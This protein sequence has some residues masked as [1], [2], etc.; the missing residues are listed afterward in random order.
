MS[1]IPFNVPRLVKEGAWLD[2]RGKYNNG[3]AGFGDR[4]LS[5][6]RFAA[7][8]HSV[9]NP[10]GNAER[11]CNTLF[12]IHAGNGWN[13]IGYNFV[14]TSE[15]VNGFAK[16]A[17][18]G[19]LGSVRAHTPNTKGAKGMAAGLGN[20]YI[21]AACMIG[22]NH[23]VPPTVAQLRSMKLLMQ[24]LLFFENDR[25]PNLWPQWDDMWPHYTWD[26]TQC[27]GF[28][29]IRQQIIDVEIPSDAPA[30]APTP[31]VKE[32]SRDVYDP[33]KKFRF[34]KDSRFYNLLEYTVNG[35]KVYPKGEE[36][37]IRQKLTLTNG[38]VWY[39][40]DYSSKG[41]IGTGFRAEDLDEIKAPEPVPVPVE[42]PKP[43]IRA[44]GAL[45]TVKVNNGDKVID[46]ITKAVT[47]TYTQDEPFEATH[48]V[49]WE[50]KIYYMTQFSHQQ[51]LN[52]KNPTGIDKDTVDAWIIV[53]TEPDPTPLPPVE[54]KPETPPELIEQHDKD[55]ADLN[56]RVGLIEQFIEMLKKAWRAIFNKNIGE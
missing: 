40:T 19:D 56:K 52:G 25:L 11:D 16:V 14:V 53:P 33:M 54:E 9:T 55:I 32:L 17:Y 23:I 4:A 7:P 10:T 35:T 5:E 45:M 28:T 12:N 41:E 37:D 27:N 46:V 29:S 2:Y 1:N 3:Y 49:E 30:P 48:T 51:Y 31:A 34:N 20:R 50:G 15:E 44:L 26:W 47:K 8:H 38:N 22:Q 18:V 42:P 36:I 13:M 24:E 21:V 39:R 43:V 6:I